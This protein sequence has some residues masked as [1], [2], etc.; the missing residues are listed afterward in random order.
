MHVWGQTKSGTS[1]NVMRGFF[2]LQVDVTA[3]FQNLSC[4]VE[5]CKLFGFPLPTKQEAVS[6][7]SK[8]EI[9]SETF[10][11]ILHLLFQ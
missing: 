9:I 1:L 2:L 7:L 5:T 11:K 3:D 8:I 6:I 10:Q 4:F